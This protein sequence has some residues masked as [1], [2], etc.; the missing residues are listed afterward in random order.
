M[1]KREILWKIEKEEEN[2]KSVPCKKGEIIHF[3]YVNWGKST[4]NID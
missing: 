3:E 1:E 2:K 4:E